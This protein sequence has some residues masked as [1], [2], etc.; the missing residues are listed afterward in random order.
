MEKL[1]IYYHKQTDSWWINQKISGFEVA[2]IIK[3]QAIGMGTIEYDTNDKNKVGGDGL[4]EIESMYIPDY[5]K[6]FNDAVEKL[7]EI[8]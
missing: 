4:Y 2:Q 3:T 1:N 7:D 6:K 5:I 8:L